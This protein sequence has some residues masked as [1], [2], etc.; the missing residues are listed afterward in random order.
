MNCKLVYYDNIST[1]MLKLLTE[2]SNYINR[3]SALNNS[4]LTNILFYRNYSFIQ[5]IYYFDIGRYYHFRCMGYMECL[6]LTKCY[7]IESLCYWKNA[8]VMPAYSNIMSGLDYLHVLE[9]DYETSHNQT[10]MALLAEI[11]GLKEVAMEIMET[12]KCYNLPC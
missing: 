2:F 10:F 1:E 3:I 5:Y 9:S 6:V 11:Q 4:L 8:L 7:S 12:I